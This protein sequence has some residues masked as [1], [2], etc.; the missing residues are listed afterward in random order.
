MRMM[1]VACINS[2]ELCRIYA[3]FHSFQLFSKNLLP[4][5]PKFYIG[6]CC[7]NALLNMQDTPSLVCIIEYDNYYIWQNHFVIQNFLFMK[8]LF[9]Q[10]SFWFCYFSIENFSTQ[11]FFDQ[12]NVLTKN[13]LPQKYW[14]CYKIAAIRLTTLIPQTRALRP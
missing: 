10:F 6:F 4:I 5:R 2:H 12:I 9:D 13:V 14:Y 11:I 7:N 3:F 8:M 1:Y